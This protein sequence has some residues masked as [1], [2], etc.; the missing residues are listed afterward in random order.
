MHRLKSKFSGCASQEG[1]SGAD[2]AL[3]SDP[4]NFIK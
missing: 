2:N 1:P 4:L 3:N